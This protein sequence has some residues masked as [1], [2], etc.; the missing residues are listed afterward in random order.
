MSIAIS[1]AAR[2]SPGVRPG[3]LVHFGQGSTDQ[4]V[5]LPL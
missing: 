1:A 5:D 2:L 4:L 3:E